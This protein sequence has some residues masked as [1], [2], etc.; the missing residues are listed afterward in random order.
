MTAM[1]VLYIMSDQH[2]QKAAG[3]YGH[4]FVK[5]PNIDRLAATGTR[6]ASAYTNSPI[7]VPARATLAT[8]RYVHETRYWD[9]AHAYDG[10][11]K[12]WHH[13]LQDA[14]L[15]AVS[16][17]KLH[18]RKEE[19]PTGFARQVSPM[20]IVDGIGDLRGSVK[21]PM[22]PPFERSK[23]ATQIGPG[24]SP[25]TKYDRD[26]AEQSCDW[27]RQEAGRAKG[28]PWVLFCSFVCPHPPHIAP[29][30]FY[31]MYPVEEMPIPKLSDPDAPL[32]PWIALQQRSRNHD[33]FLNDASRRVLMASYF[34]CTSFLDDNVGRLLDC[35][36]AS[37]LSDDT[38]VIYT[39]DHGE[40]LGARRLWG[41]SNMYEEASAVPMILSGPGVPA[42]KL[43]TTAVTLAD[44]APTILDAV[45]EGERARAEGLPGRSLL[46]IAGGEDDP[47]RIAFC[48]YF[49]ASADRA[50]F[51]IR[52]RAYKYIH[53]VGYEPELFDLESDPEEIDNLAM[54]PAHRSTVAEFDGCL[55][56]I[57]DPDAVDEQ[58]Y[59]DQVALVEKHGGRE[60]V[61]ARGGIQGTPAPGDEAEFVT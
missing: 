12:S 4:P 22:A 8:G 44:I 21:R 54:D 36:E 26:I 48:E 35:L 11:V 16:I 2:Q 13:M 7:C 46:E 15:G 45:G 40:N 23:V 10:R 49:A 57:V 31:D 5:T 19:D 51:M 32:H 43:S 24:E 9:N 42:G 3:C 29:P 60:A 25:Y 1:N 52:K 34:G 30:D 53:Y 20:H 58:A 28:R 41:K 50:A 37:G 6:F 18:F 55:R 14:G 47:E 56:A 39:S 61:L 38:I 27:L 17:G 59:R 33:D